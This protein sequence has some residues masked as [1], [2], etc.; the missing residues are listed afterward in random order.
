MNVFECTRTRHVKR[1]G[2]ED[3][4][5]NLANIGN[6]AD[7]QTMISH[8]WKFSNGLNF[9]Q[10]Q[11]GGTSGGENTVTELE[12][13]GTTT[14][15]LSYKFHVDGSVT[16]EF[17]NGR[18]SNDDSNYVKTSLKKSNG[19]VQEGDQIGSNSEP[20][21]TTFEFSDGDE[22]IIEEKHGTIQLYN[23]KT[24]PRMSLFPKGR[25]RPKRYW[26]GKQTHNYCETTVELSETKL[27]DED[28]DE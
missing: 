21:S 20:M 6:F 5:N 28:K 23:V 3:I 13:H 8:G 15:K 11:H 16:I 24:G 26:T 4:S 7:K 2:W 9:I 1:E 12:A 18:T 22:L 10:N 17:G 27:P 14:G 19:I 25:N